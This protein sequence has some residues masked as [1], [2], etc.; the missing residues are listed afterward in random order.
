MDFSGWEKLSLV[1]YD[2]NITTTLF[3]S[4]C[5]FKCPFCHNGDLVL[6]PG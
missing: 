1:D 3:T 2:D 6:H 5:N 4:G